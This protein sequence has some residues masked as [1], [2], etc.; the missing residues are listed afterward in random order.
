MPNCRHFARGFCERGSRCRFNHSLKDSVHE[1]KTVYL[2]GVPPQTTRAALRKQLHILGCTILNKRMSLHKSMPCVQLA[3]ADEAQKLL[4]KGTILIDGC[5]V[6]VRTW[7][8]VLRSKRQRL[9]AI[10]RRSIFLGGL[11]KGTTGRIIKMDL[12]RNG[13]KVVNLMKIKK[14]F[15]PKVTLANLQQ[16]EWLVSMSKVK[17]NG[18]MV[19]VRP[20]RSNGFKGKLTF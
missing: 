5:L 16:T 9:A 6:D 15:C 14:G 3:S 2:C 12:E 1:S 10:T 20:Y 4:K 19:D 7:Q 8:S 13:V 18:S 11:V 17:I